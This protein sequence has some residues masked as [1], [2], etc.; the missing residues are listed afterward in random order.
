[1]GYTPVSLSPIVNICVQITLN[2]VLQ[3]LWFYFTLTCPE[4]L[5]FPLLRFFGFETGSE[6]QVGFHLPMQMRM[7]L[8]PWFWCLHIPR[9]WITG[10]TSG[11]SSWHK[12]MI[13]ALSYSS[14]SYSSAEGKEC[15]STQTSTGARKVK[16]SAPFIGKTCLT[17]LPPGMLRMDVVY[18]LLIL[19]HLVSWALHVRSSQ[20]LC[21][22]SPR[23]LFPWNLEYYF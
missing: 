14:G 11:T 21:F 1:M 12:S 8:N 18:S 13:S 6:T 15:W 10:F 16:L 4:S 17:C 23:P 7:T 5:Y 20:S 3:E 19:C 2:P 9:A 22:T